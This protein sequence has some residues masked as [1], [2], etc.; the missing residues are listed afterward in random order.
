MSRVQKTAAANEIYGDQCDQIA[1]QRTHN[2]RKHVTLLFGE[3][4]LIQVMALQ[5]VFVHRLAHSC[6]K[7][8][9]IVL[10]V[11]AC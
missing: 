11:R 10:A 5:I 3:A 8:K 4:R 2:N 7:R 9:S 1:K 6:Q